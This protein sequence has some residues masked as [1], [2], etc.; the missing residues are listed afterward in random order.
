MVAECRE[1][2]TLAK[3]ESLVNLFRWLVSGRGMLT[4]NV[5]EACA[6]VRLGPG[7]SAPDVELIF[8]PVACIDHGLVKLER[9]GLTVAPVLLQP[10]SAGM[11]SL[12]S[13]DPL[14]PPVIEPR[15]LSDAD[16]MDLK[17]LVEGV[18]LAQRILATPPLAGYVGATITPAAGG[19]SDAALAA[20]V[21][22]K[23]ETLYHPVGTCRMGPD[24]L[25][26]VD[27]ELRVRGLRA[28][29]VADASVMPQIIRG[30]THAPAVM[31]G[32]KAA[33]LLGKM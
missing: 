19:R 17:L 6:F 3:A 9:H 32:E 20:F 14:A 29:R 18:K 5:G 7:A 16:G 12:A 28:L 15:Y 24:A 27:S 10:R 23:A 1:P 22:E 2:I 25:A 33:D 26:V 13:R 4:S 30:H 11:I 31:I 21:R 8:A